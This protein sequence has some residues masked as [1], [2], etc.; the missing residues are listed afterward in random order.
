[1]Q[2]LPAMENNIASAME[3]SRVFKHHSGYH[4][5]KLTINFGRRSS[6]S[7][8]V[9]TSHVFALPNFNFWHKTYYSM[10][11]AKRATPPSLQHKIQCLR[12]GNLLNILTIHIIKV[13]IES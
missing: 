6:L 9:L 7:Y 11:H 12:Y 3:F 1:M 8:L 4:S 10:C 13:S 5:V 2:P